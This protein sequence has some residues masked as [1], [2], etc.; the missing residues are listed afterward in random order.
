MRNRIG[1][2]AS[3]CP[4]VGAL[5]RLCGFWYAIFSGRDL[6]RCQNHILSQYVYLTNIHRPKNITNSRCMDK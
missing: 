5:S 2:D 1:E 3:T 4:I 6:V